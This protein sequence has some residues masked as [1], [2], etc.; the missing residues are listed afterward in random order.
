MDLASPGL[1]SIL[2]PQRKNEITPN[3]RL[4]PARCSRLGATG[5]TEPHEG[6]SR[7]CGFGTLRALATVDKAT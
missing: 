6:F 2:V 1:R 4:E 7:L 5:A 3:R